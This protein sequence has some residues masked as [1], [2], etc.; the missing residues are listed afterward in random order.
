[1]WEA[2]FLTVFSGRPNPARGFEVIEDEA[3]QIVADGDLA[4]LAALLIK[5]EH[6]LLSCPIEAAALQ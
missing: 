6:L 4:R 5:M 2:E 1:M 3:F